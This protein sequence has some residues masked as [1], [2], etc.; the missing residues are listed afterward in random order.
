MSLDCY[1]GD[2]RCWGYEKFQSFPYT[3]IHHST[4]TIREEYFTFSALRPSRLLL[5]LSLSLYYTAHQRLCSLFESVLENLLYIRDILRCFPKHGS[6][7]QRSIK[8]FLFKYYNWPLTGL[9]LNNIRLLE[10]YSKSNWYFTSSSQLQIFSKLLPL[11]IEPKTGS[12][13]SIL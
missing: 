2:V 3:R 11:S 6:P 13:V 9:P 7:S 12:V 5:T 8:L 10:S 4:F 1:I